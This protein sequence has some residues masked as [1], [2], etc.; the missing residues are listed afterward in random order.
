MKDQRYKAIKSLIEG[1]NLKGVK[2]IFTIVPITTVRTDLK[3]NYNTL[4]SR[5]YNP[6]LFTV[7]D[8]VGLSN[9]FEVSPEKILNLILM[10]S[11]K[12]IKVKNKSQSK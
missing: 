7:R 3:I 6:Q 2:E 4:R 1:N 8:I 11:Q 12:T 9:L 10:D 5:I